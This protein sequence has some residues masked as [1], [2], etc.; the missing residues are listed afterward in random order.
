[1]AGIFIL[2]NKRKIWKIVSSSMVATFPQ[3]FSFFMRNAFPFLPP[4][5]RHLKLKFFSSSA[6]LNIGW[7]SFEKLKRSSKNSKT[8]NPCKLLWQT[9]LFHC[10][11]YTFVNTLSC[12][13]KHYLTDRI[14]NLWSQLLNQTPM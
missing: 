7:F 8:L 12:H 10:S 13:K 3:Y 14:E 4:Q 11:L 6:F 2:E 9:L 1:L 5:S